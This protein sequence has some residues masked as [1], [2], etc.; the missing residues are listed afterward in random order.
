M[1]GWGACLWLCFFNEWNI[2]PPPLLNLSVYFE[3]YRQE[4]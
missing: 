2:L 3:R 1:I 4:Y